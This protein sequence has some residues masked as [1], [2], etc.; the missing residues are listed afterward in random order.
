MAYNRVIRNITT[1]F[2]D[3]FSYI[4]LVRYHPDETEQER[5]I[6][7]IAHA[8]KEL[9]VM[10]LQG[11][12]DADKKIQMTL[13]RM[14]LLLLILHIKHRALILPALT[15][16]QATVKQRLATIPL[17]PALQTALN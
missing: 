17:Q 5:F 1:A 12:P 2:S 8:G 15:H 14:Q 9:Y 13:P 16:Y 10:R 6:V 11:D 3:Q 7:P 4:T